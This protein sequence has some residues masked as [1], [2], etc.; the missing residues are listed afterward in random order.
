MF[1]KEFICQEC[2]HVFEDF[3]REGQRPNCPQC[4][5]DKVDVHLSGK[6]CIGRPHASCSGNCKTCSGCH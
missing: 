4:G 5:S 1:F 6:V 2:G 3:E